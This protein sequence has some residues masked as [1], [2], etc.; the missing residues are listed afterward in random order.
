MDEIVFTDIEKRDIEHIA[1]LAYDWDRL[2]NSKVLI[3]GGSGFI[4]T[5][6]TA[7]FE[8]RNRIYGDNIKTIS[9]SRH[10]HADFGNVKHIQKDITEKIDVDGAVDYIIHLASN[11][12]PVQYAED[13]VG[14]I[15]TNMVGCNNLLELAVAK[16]SERF[17][18]ASSVEIYGNGSKE[19]MDENYCG[20]INCNTVRAGYNESKRVSESLCQ[21]FK[22]QYGVDCVIARLAR[23]FGADRKNDSKAMAQ[24]INKAVRGE[25]IV[26]K[27]AGKQRFSYCYI[28][29]A[30]SGILKVLLDGQ[31][32]EAYNIAADDEGLTLG[33]YAEYIA[34]LSKSHIKYDLNDG[35]VGASQAAVALLDCTKLK[36]L[37]WQPMYRVAEG[38][39]KTYR[40]YRYR[41]GE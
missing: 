8:E 41:Q 19:P 26:L 5:H 15:K 20:Y 7:V 29:D 22:Q 35:Q 17:L 32:G 23:V 24:F 1:S 39:E 3:S 12:H 10:A 27:S 34:N 9:L 30:V 38:I 13:P 33:D 21:A 2:K 36:T 4:G 40:N 28:A 25:D 37:S 16:K 14:T 6:L 11:T 31:N 18:L